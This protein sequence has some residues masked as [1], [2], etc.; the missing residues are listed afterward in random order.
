MEFFER[1]LE[2]HKELETRMNK[3]HTALLTEGFIEKVGNMQYKLMWQQLAGM[4]LYYKALSD[5]ITNLGFE[6]QNI[7]LKPNEEKKN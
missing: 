7:K 4:Q 1:M 2:E 6:M 3:L 5:R